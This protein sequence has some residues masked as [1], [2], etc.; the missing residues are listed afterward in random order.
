MTWSAPRLYFGGD[1]NPEQW[2]R[3]SWRGDVEQMQRIG[4]N[5]VTLGVF[6]WASIEVSDGDYRFDW[7]DDAMDVLHDGGIRVDLATAT[8]SPPAWLTT[9]YP[10]VCA[11]TRDGVR[12]S[13]GGRQH[14]SPSSAIYRQKS[15]Q[16]VEQIASRYAKH[17]A[18]EM[19]HVNNELG[20]HTPH[21]FGEESAQGFRDWLRERYESVERLNDAWQT[22]FWSQL[23]H[24]FDEVE[25]PR[26]T[27]AG[28]H[29]NPGQ[30]Q[31][32]MHFSS[33]TLLEQYLAERD[34]I[35]R[36]DSTHPITTNFMSMRHISALDYWKW[37]REVDFVSTDHYAEAHNP[38][39]HIE[40]AFQA[41]LTRGFAGGKPWLLLEHSPAAVNWQP[42]NAPKTSSETI[43]HAMSH[44]G[45]GSEGVMFFQFKQSRGGSERYHSAMVPHVGED[46]RVFRTMEE[47][48]RRIGELEP[49][50]GAPTSPASVAM[51]LDYHSWWALQQAN[52]PST[53]LDYVG[54][55]HQ[56]YE[57]LYDLGIGVDFIDPD[58]S[59]ET[60][61]V[62]DAVL[63]PLLHI[64]EDDR[65]RVISDYVSGG[66]RILTSY[67]SGTADCKLN[68][69]LGGY[70]GELLR[71]VCGV[72][73]EEFVPLREHETLTLSNGWRGSVWSERAHCLTAIDIACYRFGDI[74]E[75]SV[76]VSK[77]SY[78]SGQ[79]WYVGT[80]L[81]PD[82]LAALLGT[83]LEGLPIRLRGD[84]SMEIL[85]RGGRSIVINHA[86]TAGEYS[87]YLVSAGDTVVVE[88]EEQ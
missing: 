49:I 5:L 51:A 75:S 32:F 8:A 31:D 13:H 76:A 29:P 41:D 28:T 34:A 12:L 58:S 40:L 46:S 4:V 66:G 80:L 72:F 65:L 20:C 48:G 44:I 39:A 64:V 14:Y 63:L 38:K 70:G 71:D 62:Y 3:D 30:M 15:V 78:G 43:R 18:L 53:D 73:V 82:N 36:F 52:L 27:S 23:Y 79:A 61:Q 42:R 88:R 87:G 86:P 83:F 26:T 68:V 47:L 84:G 85:E 24:S 6:S 69:H 55:V 81:E 54:L 25:P 7:L 1:Y 21:C 67:F 37:A 17:P 10:S 11:V 59:L 77:N 16:L 45:R 33:D 19:W 50:A 9:Q 57:A 2:P 56:W 22:R 60:W 74:V 35:R